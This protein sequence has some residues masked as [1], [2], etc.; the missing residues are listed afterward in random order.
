[1]NETNAPGLMDRLTDQLDYV[2]WAIITLSKSGQLQ[3]N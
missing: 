3:L 1:M 2:L